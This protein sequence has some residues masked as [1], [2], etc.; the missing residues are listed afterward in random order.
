VSDAQQEPVRILTAGLPDVSVNEVADFFGANRGEFRKQLQQLNDA[1]GG[2]L[3]WAK[4]TA[5][6]AKLW[7]RWALVRELFPS[8]FDS[9]PEPSAIDVLELRQ[10][11]ISLGQRLARLE[12][13]RKVDAK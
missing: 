12:Q 13:R 11:C 8:W 5:R 10:T 9:L 4:S 1:R 3:L 2:G 6:N 7:T